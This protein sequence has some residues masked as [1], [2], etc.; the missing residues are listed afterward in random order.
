MRIIA[1]EKRRMTLRCP[2]GE[3]TRPTTERVRESLFG[4]L[5]PR[6]PGARVL[7]LFA[8]AGTLG[9]EAL[10]RGAAHATLVDDYPKALDAL[11]SN[12]ERLEMGDRAR[13][14]RSDAVK[15]LKREAPAEAPFDIILADPPYGQNLGPAL[16]EALAARPAEWLSPDGIL[17]LQTGKRDR[18][19]A[20]YGDL[21]RTRTREYGETHIHFFAHESMLAPQA[22]EGS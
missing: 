3:K 12:I 22:E 4:S 16:L 11:K 7:D 10:S 1:G 13:V 6:L 8:G 5:D 21:H 14:V 9:L 20:K 18:I 19:E 15:F 2:P 17:A